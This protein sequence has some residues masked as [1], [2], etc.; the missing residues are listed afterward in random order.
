MQ[1]ADPVGNRHHQVHVV[2]DQDQGDV[3]GAAATQCDGA[4]PRSRR[5]SAR[6][7]AR[8]CRTTR[9]PAT[10]A[11]ASSTNFCSPYDR[12]A[13][14]RSAWARQPERLERRHA[15]RPPLFARG[16]A[17]EHGIGEQARERGRNQRHLQVLQHGDAVEQPDVLIG[18]AEP[19]ARDP[20]LRAATAVRV[21]SSRMRPELTRYDPAA[22]LTRVDLPAPFGPMMDVTC[23]GAIAS[24]TSS[25]ATSAPKRL[26][27]RSKTS[28]SAP[29]ASPGARTG[30]V[31][32]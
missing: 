30:R 9:G 31:G 23:P 14:S 17:W 4:A 11:R 12:F 20:V 7:P 10:T 19:G 29:I 8:R 15:A 18:A 2:L 6:P 5:G 25:M 27:T 21:R 28:I 16:P 22:M 24:E 32:V 26:L 1:D 3:A 13:A